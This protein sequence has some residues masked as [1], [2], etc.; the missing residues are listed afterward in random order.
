[1]SV[2][3]FTLLLHDFPGFVALNEAALELLSMVH[4][5]LVSFPYL[6]WII[7]GSWRPIFGKS[8]IRTSYGLTAVTRDGVHP[9][10]FDRP[11]CLGI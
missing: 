7:T 10:N 4:P 5:N 8:G 11:T 9:G 1:M 3:T 2:K 6:R